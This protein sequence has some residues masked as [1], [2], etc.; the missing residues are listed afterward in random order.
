MDQQTIVGNLN[1]EINRLKTFNKEWPHAYISPKKLAKTGLYY[2]GPHDQVECLFC[3]IKISSWEM[4]DNEVLEHERWSRNCP[5]LNGQITLNIPFGPI[6]ELKEL[7]STVSDKIR[8]PVWIE[9]YVETPSFFF[10]KE[11]TSE[12]R[13]DFPEFMDEPK[14]LQTYENWPK[15]STQSPNQLSEAGFFYTQKEDRVICFSCGGGLYKW[16]EQDNSWEQHA[17]WYGTCKYMQDKKGEK[18]IRKVKHSFNV[19]RLYFDIV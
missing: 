2:I 18:F 6:Q 4:G 15:S 17:L 7:L 16:M 14:R 8:E 5:L 9:K 10:K 12:N 1:E 11:R 19:D 13:P 3:K